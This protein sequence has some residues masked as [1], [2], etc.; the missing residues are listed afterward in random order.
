[1]HHLPIITIETSIACIKNELA[2]IIDISSILYQ[3]SLWRWETEANVD[4]DDGLGSKVWHHAQMVQTLLNRSFTKLI[5][6][7]NARIISREVPPRFVTVLWPR[8]SLHKQ[9]QH[10][11]GMQ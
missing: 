2:E 8:L 4:F 3:A 1:L 9:I 6:I 10:F 7:P 5:L 11:G